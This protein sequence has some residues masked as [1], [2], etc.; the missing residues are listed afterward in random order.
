MIG[1]LL[2]INVPVPT[3]TMVKVGIDLKAYIYV[4]PDLSYM[5][6]SPT[7]L[8]VSITMT[9]GKPA[10]EQERTARLNALS[11]VSFGRCIY[12]AMSNGFTLSPKSQGTSL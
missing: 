2:K 8:Y 3:S 5:L 6:L 1:E 7:H 10:A 12:S 11:L 4:I 9:Y